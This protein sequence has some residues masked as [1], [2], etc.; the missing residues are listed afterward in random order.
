MA[1]PRREVYASYG[2]RG[3]R[4]RLCSL[5]ALKPVRGGRI[6]EAKSNESGLICWDEAGAP[7]EAEA[8]SKTGLHMSETSLTFGNPPNTNV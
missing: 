4:W 3:C 2:G 8:F 7:H 5:P 1:M 6:R